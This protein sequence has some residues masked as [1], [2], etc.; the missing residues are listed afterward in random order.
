MME[1]YKHVGSH[2]KSRGVIVLYNKNK[3]KVDDVAIIQ[4]GMLLS[5]RLK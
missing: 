4:E 5:F 1:N 2:T 3:T